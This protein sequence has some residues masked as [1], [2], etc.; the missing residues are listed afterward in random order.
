MKLELFMKGGDFHKLGEQIRKLV[1]ILEEEKSRSMYQPIRDEVNIIR[2][3]Y[4]L[5]EIELQDEKTKDANKRRITPRKRFP[6]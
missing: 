6:D 2:V 3:L 4:K 1:K 5:T